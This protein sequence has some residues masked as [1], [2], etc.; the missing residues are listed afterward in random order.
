MIDADQEGGY[1]FKPMMDRDY[2]R[3]QKADSD[4][5]G[6]LTKME[7]Q[8]SLHPEDAE[9][10]RD[11]LVIETLEDMDTDKDG[12]LS[13]D[14]Y[15]GDMYKELPGDGEPD[16]VTQ[17]KTLFGTERDKDGDGFMSFEEV[18]QWIIPDDFDHTL[19]EAKHLIVKSDMNGDSFLSK[20]E[21][22]DQHDMFV[23]HL[24]LNLGRSSEGIRSSDIFYCMHYKFMK[25]NLKYKFLWTNEY[26]IYNTLLAKS[27]FI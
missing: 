16:W 17:E 23:G 19:G 14:E 26:F 8:A 9:Y 12:S 7:F 18:K 11:I 20:E 5:D 27:S 24:L 22:L 1:N 21:V 10:M 4:G 6:K 25:T 15:I 3:W 13:M 2:R